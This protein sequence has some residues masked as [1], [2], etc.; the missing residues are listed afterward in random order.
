MALITETEFDIRD[1]ARAL[2][3]DAPAYVEADAPDLFR[4]WADRVEVVALLDRRGLYAQSEIDEANRFAKMM[5]ASRRT[6]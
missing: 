3:L 4:E 2:C 1:L 5:P 6:A